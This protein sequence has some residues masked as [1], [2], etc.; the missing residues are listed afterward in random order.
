[1]PFD[2]FAA[3]LDGDGILDLASTQSQ[4]RQNGN[5]QTV[6]LAHGIGTGQFQPYLDMVLSGAAMGQPVA[7]DFNGDGKMDIAVWRQSP[8]ALLVMW[9][10][11]DDTVQV[12][13]AWNPGAAVSGT[14]LAADVD[15]NG[16]QDVVLLS[17]DR[18][19]IYR[20]THGNPPLLQSVSF[21]PSTV[22]GGGAL[23]QDTVTLGG[24]D[25]AGGATITLSSDNP[26]IDLPVNPSVNIPAGMS[27]TTFDVSA[28]GVASAT[29][30]NISGAWNSV[31]QTSTLQ[32]FAP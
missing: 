21:S 24:P 17:A 26:S 13:V 6:H 32:V 1:M 27:S 25:P 8:A 4:Q 5:V 20:N 10:V 15:G 30:V 3:D 7:G 29:V 12:P 23:A 14:L 19:T 2:T 16:S 28:G 22:V 9:V 18:V 11:G 31:T